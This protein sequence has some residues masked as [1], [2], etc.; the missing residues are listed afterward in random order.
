MPPPRCSTLPD[1]AGPDHGGLPAVIETVAELSSTNTALLERLGRGEAVSE[2]HWLVADRQS[3]GRGRAGRVWTDGQGN[4]MGSTLAH[5]RAG[6]PLAP[7][8]ALV[9]GLALFEAVVQVAL[10]PREGGGLVPPGATPSEAPAF[11]GEPLMLK[12]PNDLLIGTAKLAGVLLERQR[13][14]VVVG[15]G[16]NLASAPDVPGRATTSLAGSIA[17]DDFAVVLAD[18]WQAL[19]QRWHHGEWPT[20]RQEWLARAHPSGT[21]LSVN[22]AAQ[23][24]VIGAFA[25]LDPDGAAVLRLADG[26]TRAIHAGDLDLVGG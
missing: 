11:A 12:W 13:D 21:L 22:D 10:P 3:A 14:A 24:T 5:L 16:V 2:G 23:G 8:L 9:A 18:R 6:D 19:L 20:L 25:G 15:I 26:Q 7:T 4:F 1:G 17:R